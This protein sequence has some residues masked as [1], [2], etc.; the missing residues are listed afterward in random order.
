[1]TNKIEEGCWAEI[2]GSGTPADGEIVQVYFKDV[3]VNGHPTWVISVEFVNGA[4]FLTDRCYEAF[5]RPANK[6]KLVRE[7]CTDWNDVKTSIGWLPDSL[8]TVN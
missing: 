3:D 6:P 1:M 2:Y 8:R 7:L 4:G 5:L